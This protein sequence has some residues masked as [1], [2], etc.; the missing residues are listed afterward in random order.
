[1]TWNANTESDLDG[2][3][4]YRAL[5]LNGP[6]I[7]ISSLLKTTSLIDG[8]LEN[9]TTYYYRVSAQD[10]NRNESSPSPIAFATPRAELPAP[11]GLKATPGGGEVTLSWDPVSSLNL[12]GYNVYRSTSATDIGTKLNASPIP[13]TT[14]TDTGLINGVTYYYRVSAV[15]NT[16]VEGAKSDP[17]SVTPTPIGLFFKDV[18]QD[19]WAAN[20]ISHLAG[21]G[22]V[23]GYPDGT[24]RP[25]N[26][27]TRAEFAKIIILG[28]KESPN[29]TYKGYFKDV[30]SSHWAVGYI[31][32]AKEL[33]I[34]SGYPDQTFR[35]NNFITRAEI[36]KMVVVAGGYQL[37]TSGAT[38]SDVSKNHWAYAYILTARQKQIVSGYPD[39]TFRPNNNAS[40][41]EASKMV[42]VWISSQ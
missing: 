19:S 30:S 25:N 34:I 29:P 28:L 27:I 35:P 21:E 7:K 26:S 11:T 22:L 38:F 20:Y 5:S 10:V 3:N 1:L 6:W 14:Y 17:I 23:G 8:D 37:V 18:P 36:A 4:V 40:R 15:D 16:G 39:G 33:G 13:G 2:Y 12:A 24:F 41:A 9:G 42:S 32:R 31:E